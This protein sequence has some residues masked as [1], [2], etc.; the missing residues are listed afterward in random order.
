MAVVLYTITAKTQFSFSLDFY[1]QNNFRAIEDFL[2]SLPT[3][4][5][6]TSKPL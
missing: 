1:N 3:C 6:F 2:S 5:N 4:K